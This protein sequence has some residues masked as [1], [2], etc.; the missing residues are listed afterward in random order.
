[1]LLTTFASGSTGNC[2]LLSLGG[3]HVLIDA[4][5]SWRRICGNLRLSGVAPEQLAGVAVTHS[6]SDHISGLATMAKYSDVPILAPPLVAEE[7]CRMVPGTQ[8]LIRRIPVGEDI[9]LGAVTLRA[10]HTPHDTAESVGYRLACGEEAFAVA[11]DMGHVTPEIL[12]QLS[13]AQVALIEANHDPELLKSGP[14]PLQLKR[15]ILSDR[16]HLSNEAC[17]S[18]AA[19]LAE[20]GARYLILGHL[21]RENNR[22]DLALRTVTEAV[23]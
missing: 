22:P 23:R 16:G 5:I 12:E 20:R 14:Y 11:T 19:A 6:H 7:L 21:S 15:R 3:V 10:F 9:P 17:A 18:L 13:G 4:G 1:M 2:L 8:R